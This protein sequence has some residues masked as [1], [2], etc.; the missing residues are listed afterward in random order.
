MYNSNRLGWKEKSSMSEI[1]PEMDFG[2]NCRNLVKDEFPPADGRCSA[3]IKRYA[4]PERSDCDSETPVSL[5]VAA[6][7]LRVPEEEVI[8]RAKSGEF[9]YSFP[10]NVARRIKINVSNG[11]ISLTVNEAA[12]R[13]KLEVAEIER[14]IAAGEYQP[15]YPDE[16]MHVVILN[17]WKYEKCPLL[18]TGGVCYDYKP[19]DGPK[20]FCIADVA[21]MEGQR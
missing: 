6:R 9:E 21:K 5:K 17:R 14:R 8:R 11:E 12:K 20:I 4:V 1:Q 7:F 3:A 19:H 15:F 10:E 13:L 18:E 2:L 16:L